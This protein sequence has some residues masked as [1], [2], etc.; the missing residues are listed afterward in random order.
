MFS[1]FASI[2]TM[3][4][5]CIWD[6]PKDVLYTISFEIK[7]K[8]IEYYD[9]SEVKDL[10]YLLDL[11]EDNINDEYIEILDKY[12]N[13][14][15]AHKLYFL[16]KK[17]KIK[18]GTVHQITINNINGKPVNIES[19]YKKSN[20]GSLCDVFGLDVGKKYWTFAYTLFE[21]YKFNLNVCNLRSNMESYQ[22][23][24]DIGYF[25]CLEEDVMKLAN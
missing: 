20:R 7:N 18:K 22:A 21:D 13:L 9:L 4:C 10:D 15:D 11:V 6:T 17:L 5:S 1:L 16:K 2:L 12:W 23:Y 19:E 3:V 8:K 14:N 24:Y 25:D